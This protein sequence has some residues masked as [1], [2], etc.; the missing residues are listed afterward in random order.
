MKN[1]IFKFFTVLLFLP[2]IVSTFAQQKTVVQVPA[3][4]L[5]PKV[6]VPTAKLIVADLQY[7]RIDGQISACVLQG[8]V[9]RS[10]TAKIY[11]MN[12]YC[13]DNRGAWKN[14]SLPGYPNQAQIAGTWLKEVFEAVPKEVLKTNPKIVN[15]GLMVLVAKFKSF[16]KGLIIYD[17][18]LEDATI[19]AATT[20][21]GQTDGLVVSPEIASLL[22]GY[23]FPVLKDLRELRF[24]DNIDCLA[25]LK[26]N[27]FK[28]ANKQMAFTWSHMNTGKSSWGAA[29]KDYVV[30]NRLFTFYLNIENKAESKLYASVIKEYP[31][32]TPVMG[33]TDERFADKLFADQGYFMVPVIA[34]ENLS[35]FSSYPSVSGQQ[36]KP[37]AYPVSNNAVYISFQVPDGDN[38][39]HTIVYEPYTILKSPSF[40]EIPLTWIINPG[41]VDLAPSAYR[42]YLNKFKNTNQE[43]AAM[44]GD[45]SPLSDRYEGF[46]F[47]CDFTKHY[48]EQSGILSMKQMAEGEAGSWKIQPY[49]MNSGYAGTDFRGPG[50]YEYH[51]NDQSFHIGTSHISEHD[52]KQIIKNAPANQPLFLTIFAGT[53]AADTPTLVKK[54]CDELTAQN[55]GRKYYFVRSMDLAATYRFFKGLPIQ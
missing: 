2:G 21:A 39:L 52:I 5:Y 25:W 53:A 33:W 16:I 55:D 29:N 35:V 47:Y 36:P 11:V 38:L 6:T 24:K 50:P 10:S 13:A 17:P 34:V 8:I 28:N 30:A 23:N 4:R 54:F 37:K 48:M 15:P 49:V 43:L 12:T 22:K 40:G 9:N 14:D 1:S 32:G 51:L 31:A 3:G 20:I 46:S 41:I 19:E 45:G 27:Y 42:W 44:M 26:T 18:N 7:D